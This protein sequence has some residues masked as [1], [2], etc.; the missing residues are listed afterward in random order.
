MGKSTLSRKELF[1]KFYPKNSKPDGDPLFD[2]YSR[3]SFDKRKAFDAQFYTTDQ[4]LANRRGTITSTLAPYTGPW[5]K[6][7]AAH[8]LRRTQFSFTKA[9]LDTISGMQMV[10]AVQA[11]LKNNT[12]PITPPVNW[13]NNDAPDENNLPYGADWTQDVF[14]DFTIGLTSNLY[15]WIGLQGWNAGQALNQELNIQEK[16]T[17]FWYHFIPIDFDAVFQSPNAYCATNSARISYSY[18]QLFRTAGLG[19]FKDLI[20]KVSVHPAM[21]Y[22][23]NNQANTKTAP[24][25]NFAREIMELFTLGKGEDSLYSQ[26]D[27][28]QAAKIL[29]GWRVLNLNT[30]NPTAEF[31]PNLHDTS[32]KTFSAFFNNTSIAGTGADELDKFIDLIFT[33]SEVISKYI[34]RRLYRYF[35][36]Y[37]IDEYTEET[38]IKPLAEAMVFNGWDIKLTLQKLFSSEHFYDMANRGVYIKSPFDL[39][40]GSLR[41][42][43]VQTNSADASNHDAQY[44]IWLYLQNV[45][46]KQMDQIMG[47]VPNVSGWQAFYQKPSYH[48]YWINSNT[49]QQR[50]LF[51]E[52]I[53][54]GFNLTYNGQTTRIQVDVIAWAKQFDSTTAKDPN[55]LT[56]AAIDILLTRDLS[57]AQRNILKT[58]TL[59]SNQSTDSYWTNAWETYLADPSNTANENIVKSRLI[60]LLKS[61]AQLAE[62]QLM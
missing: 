37:D 19:N 18:I 56:Q 36:Y 50:F 33:K 14:D 49:L 16:M 10:Y 2:K 57:L 51:I 7:E 27:V 3:K 26:S 20:K 25:E 15:R 47:T 8:L 60:G 48:E 46:M 9:D 5:T 45:F 53:F 21:M 61:I 35:V 22:Y 23:L 4:A 58:Q 30:A 59:L 12:N 13:Y 1:E 39:V 11:L 43:K 42:L 31:V 6:K 28:L 40:L 52:R 44:K 55:L 29:T 54:S 62:Y 41:Q 32:T 38:I 24:D 17:W 34:C